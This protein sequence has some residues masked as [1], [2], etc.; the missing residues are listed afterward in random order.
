MVIMKLACSVQKR[1]RAVGAGSA[2]Q[3]SSGA[4]SD[5][6]LREQYFRCFLHLRVA[7][8]FQESSNEIGNSNHQA[9]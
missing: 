5:K 3:V 9:F 8:F 4:R 6:S 7:G 1:L 2:G